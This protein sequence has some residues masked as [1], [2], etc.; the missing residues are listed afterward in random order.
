MLYF[1][2]TGPHVPLRQLKD[3]HTQKHQPS[4]TFLV[5]LWISFRQ[6]ITFTDQTTATGTSSWAG[7]QT[8]VQDNFHFHSDHILLTFCFNLILLLFV[9]FLCIYPLLFWFGQ[10]VFGFRNVSIAQTIIWEVIFRLIHLL[11]FYKV[12]N[13]KNVNSAGWKQWC[14]ML[15]VARLLDFS[16]NCSPSLI[17]NFKAFSSTFPKGFFCL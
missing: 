8:P 3:Q 10:N 7:T 15:R 5:W 11:L 1:I 6:I 14:E 16:N 12:Y 2:Q 13:F 17:C 9:N 4:I